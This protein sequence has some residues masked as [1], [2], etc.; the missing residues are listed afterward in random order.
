[1]TEINIS[2]V[3]VRWIEHASRRILLLD[4]SH[5]TVG[6]SLAL[7]ADF[8]KIVDAEPDDSV[9]LLSNVTGA[10]YDSAVAQQWKAARFER[11]HKIRR[12]SIYGLSGLVG[13][14]VRAF[15]QALALFGKKT[16][17]RIC[18]NLEDSL[19]WLEEGD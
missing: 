9:Y 2:L 6:E 18:G 3:R 8:C 7:I 15:H 4:F 16:D 19:K 5:A 13:I 14:A 10:V 17:L 11:T 1:M 12:S